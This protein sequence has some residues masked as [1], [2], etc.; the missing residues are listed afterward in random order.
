MQLTES[1]KVWGTPAFKEVLKSEIEQLGLDQLPL[2]QGL[3]QTSYVSDKGFQAMIIKVTDGQPGIRA[4][5]GFFYSGIIAGCSCADDPTPVDLL[6]EYC[7]MQFDI[8][9]Q[10]GETTVILLTEGD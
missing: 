6:S 9:R 5:V 3:S 8:N 2:Q 1:L 7:E 4:K 10:T